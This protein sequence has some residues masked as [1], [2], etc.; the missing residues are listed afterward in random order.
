MKW[1][2]KQH[3]SM[4]NPLHYTLAQAIQESGW[5]VGGAEGVTVDREAG[6]STGSDL[7]RFQLPPQSRK[8]SISWLCVL[9]SSQIPPVLCTT[10]PS[11]PK[12][13]LPIIWLQPRQKWGCRDGAVAQSS[14]SLK[15]FCLQECPI[16]C[17]SS[18]T[19]T[20]RNGFTLP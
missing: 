16:I 15:H 2:D 9:L 6:W 19:P 13:A 1:G 3:P 4:I 7:K 11:A 12:P 18:T 10:R 20:Q 8:R 17:H 14:R 5:S